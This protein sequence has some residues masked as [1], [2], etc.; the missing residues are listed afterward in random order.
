MELGSFFND[1]PAP[2]LEWFNVRYGI[3]LDAHLNG[4]PGA[5]GYKV[6]IHTGDNILKLIAAL[7]AGEINPASLKIDFDHA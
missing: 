4:A 3:F 6:A 2:D 1:S 5:G 7:R